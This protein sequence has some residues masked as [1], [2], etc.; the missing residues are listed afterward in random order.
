MSSLQR[1]DPDARGTTAWKL[2]A[3]AA[4][5]RRKD[6]YAAD[7]AC[8]PT[9]VGPRRMDAARRGELSVSFRGHMRV[10][11]EQELTS[12]PVVGTNRDE[13][14]S[15]RLAGES[16]RTD[17]GVE[18]IRSF[19]FAREL[20]RSPKVKQ[21]GAGADQ[22][23]VGNPEHVPVFYL[24]GESHKRRRAAITKFFT[25]KTV[26]TRYRAVME[27]TTDRLLERLKA[28]GSAQ[29]DD[30]SFELAVSV[31]SDIVGL[32]SEPREMAPRI[33][34]LLDCTFRNVTGLRLAIKKVKELW[35]G[36][37]FYRYDVRPAVRARRAQRREDII[38]QVIDKGYSEKA[39]MIECLTYATAG[40]VTTREF[41]VMVAWYLFERPELRADFMAADEEGQF[42]IL[43]E[44]L[45]LEPIAGLIYRRAEE[46]LQSSV[47][48]KAV[49]AG[50]KFAIDL[51]AVNSDEAAVGACPFAIDPDRAKRQNQNSTFMS[52]GDGSH[53]CPGWQVALNETRVFVDRLFRVPG[54][55]LER[56]P[57]MLW[58]GP[59]MS[60]EL[61]NAVVA[62]DRQGS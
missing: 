30:L 11:R 17:A 58:N 26:E 4:A 50:A 7:N 38:S 13:R 24:D 33:S 35:Y 52:F 6:W 9:D 54:I 18:V 59:L 28:T 22:I 56:A 23:D 5:S 20:L 32:E 60:Y 44:I 14:K 19:G 29:L 45:R 31:V 48:G 53:R 16:L 57:D 15:A 39:I 21:D 62:C 1:I 61:R 46:E 10:Q 40:M 34:A 3:L 55:R 8:L 2:A 43:H 47:R 37:Q 49:K 27:R 12:G 25:P 42:L 41:M 36:L 51:R